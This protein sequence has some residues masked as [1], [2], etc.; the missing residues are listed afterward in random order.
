MKPW[1]EG[2][3]SA[4]G[5]FVLLVRSV[6]ARSGSERRSSREA[7]T[8]P[9]NWTDPDDGRV[10]CFN[11]ARLPSIFENWPKTYSRKAGEALARMNRERRPSTERANSRN[12]LRRDRHVSLK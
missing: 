4:H 10:Y 12:C 1:A 6:T 9:S 2:A 3:C 5:S 7:S 8:G 11:S